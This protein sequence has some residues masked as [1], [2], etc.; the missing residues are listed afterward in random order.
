MLR[1]KGGVVKGGCE[2]SLIAYD[3]MITTFLPF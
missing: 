1:V 2:R 3:V